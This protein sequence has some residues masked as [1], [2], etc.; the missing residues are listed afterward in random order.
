M[1]E[2]HKKGT[3]KYN[4]KL[5]CITKELKTEKEPRTLSPYRKKYQTVTIKVIKK[6]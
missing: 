1:C 5:K 4:R 2:T 3:T 6:R